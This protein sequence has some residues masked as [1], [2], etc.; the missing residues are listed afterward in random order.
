MDSNDNTTDSRRRLAQY[1][2]EM[3]LQAGFQGAEY[4]FTDD[5]GRLWSVELRVIAQ[6]RGQ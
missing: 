3:I 6:R 1:L 4:Q 2:V 5:D